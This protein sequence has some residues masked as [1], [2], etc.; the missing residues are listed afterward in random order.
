MDNSKAYALWTSG[1]DRS[2]TIPIE[3][4]DFIHDVRRV[5]D[6]QLGGTRTDHDSYTEPATS[7]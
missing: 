3:A 6:G 1:A 5:S 7:Y 4:G 2:I